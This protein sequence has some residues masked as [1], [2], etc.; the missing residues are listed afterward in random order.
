MTRIFC[1]KCCRVLNF[2]PNRDKEGNI[3]N[4]T[5]GGRSSCEHKL[6]IDYV[7]KN[8]V[9]VKWFLADGRALVPQNPIPKKW[10]VK[11]PK[12]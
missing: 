5:A 2:Y 9:V 7:K 1:D 8:K 12:K 3:I 11:E 6:S 10:V 4:Y